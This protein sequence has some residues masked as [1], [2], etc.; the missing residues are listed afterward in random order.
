MQIHFPLITKPWIWMFFTTMMGYTRLW[1]NLKS[2]RD[3]SPTGSIEILEDVSFRVILKDWW[4]KWQCLPFS[5]SWPGGWKRGDNRI[6]GLWFW[7]GG[8]KHLPC[9]SAQG[10]GKFQAEPV[11]FFLWQKW[12]TFKCSLDLNFYAL[13]IGFFRSA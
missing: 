9:T 8:L 12:I 10:S 7:N 11:S 5:W 2:W 13:I 1:E 3:E 4:S 6:R